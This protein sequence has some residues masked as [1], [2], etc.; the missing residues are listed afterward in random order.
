MPIGGTSYQPQAMPQQGLQRAAITPQEA[1]RVLSLRL[2]KTP[3]GSPIPSGLLN[4]AGGGGAN[5]TQLLQMLMQAARGGQP[6]QK[7]LVDGGDVTAIDNGLN[8]T[9]RSYTPPRIR[10]G[11]GE[12]GRVDE[13][14]MPPD[15]GLFGG[16]DPN[17]G[18]ILAKL[19]GNTGFAGGLPG[20]LN[21][22]YGRGEPLF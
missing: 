5:L 20:G 18:D 15:Q 1:V 3:Q 19:G 9:G 6:G 17:T 4:S 10:P 7:A 14:F 16:G 2:P 11:G 12:G 22:M 13:G 8:T 21:Q